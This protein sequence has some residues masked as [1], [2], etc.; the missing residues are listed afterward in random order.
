MLQF[1]RMLRPLKTRPSQGRRLGFF[2]LFLALG[3]LAFGM[4]VVRAE[5]RIAL[6]IGNGDYR[7]IAALANP[8]E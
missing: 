7:N 8:P 1:S 3:F 4:T 6:V 5:T 2:C